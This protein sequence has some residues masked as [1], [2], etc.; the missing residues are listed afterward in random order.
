MTHNHELQKL[1][2]QWETLSKKLS[3]MSHNNHIKSLLCNTHAIITNHLI[4]HTQDNSRWHTKLTTH[5][6]R[7]QEK[8]QTCIDDDHAMNANWIMPST[9]TSN[10]K[11]VNASVPKNKSQWETLITM[12]CIADFDQTIH[13]T[14]KYT[15]IAQPSR[16]KID[17][18][19]NSQRR[20][21]K[22]NQDWKENPNTKRKWK[23]QV[24][25]TTLDVGW[26]QY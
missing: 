20:N 4:S 8:T 2:D 12:W 22:S 11:H 9:T 18:K 19:H 15:K 23:T 26:T 14:H 24:C 10:Q 3:Q 21:D 16:S 7:R 5:R 1:V 25:M 13:L 17:E 6:M